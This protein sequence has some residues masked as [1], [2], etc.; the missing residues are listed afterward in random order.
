MKKVVLIAPANDYTRDEWATLIAPPLGILALGSYLAEHDIPVELIDVQVDFG[1]GLSRD[2]EQIVSQRVVHHLHE[3]ADDIAWIGVSQM[4]NTDSGLVLAQDVHDALPNIPIVFGG[5]FPSSRYSNL[6][7]E[8]PFIDAIVRGDGE[9]AALEITRHIIRGRPFPS[10]GIPNLVWTEQGEIK[11]TSSQPMSIDSLPPLDF[12]LLQKPDSYQIID[13]MTSRGCPFGCTY[14]LEDTMRPYAAFSPDW[15]V[16]QLA[17]LEATMPNTRIFIYDPVFG[18]GRKRTLEICEVMDKYGFTYGVD[19]RV[20]VLEATVIPAL[21]SAGV[22]VV[23][24]GMESASPS[25]L[26]RMKKVR[27]TT[28]AESYIKKALDLLKVCFENNVTPVLGFMIPFPGD[29]EEDFQASVDFVERVKQIYD[30]VTAQTGMET[31]FLPYAWPTRI[32][33]GTPLAAQIEAGFYPTTV[34]QAEPFAGE[35]TVLS[36]SPDLSLDIINHYRDQIEQYGTYKP[37]VL[38]RL[39]RYIAISIAQLESFLAE[40]PELINDQGIIRLGDSAKRLIP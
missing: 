36:S 39:Q 10:V 20:D 29:S 21:H 28:R 40:N 2:A 16:R 12:G 9:A 8:Y 37:R 18:L 38:E 13:L 22:E 19:S 4:F 30:Q 7:T 33:D 14:C 24:L 27:S 26:V 23:F 25:T 34:L 32:Y 1:F 3:Q 17:H 11:M 15:V 6:L 35:K 5:Y 31:G